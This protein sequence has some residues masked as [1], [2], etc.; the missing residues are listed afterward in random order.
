MVTPTSKFANKIFKIMFNNK[1]KR[2]K[3]LI[4][5]L[6]EP[7]NGTKVGKKRANKIYNNYVWSIEKYKNEYKFDCKSY[8]KKCMDKINA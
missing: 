2:A 1:P 3:E 8:V 5:K 4:S 7:Y 6:K